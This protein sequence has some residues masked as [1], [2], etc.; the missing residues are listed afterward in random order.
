MKKIP[1][2][3]P[4]LNQYGPVL[5]IQCENAIS[6][7]KTLVSEWLQKYMFASRDAA[8]I[9]QSIA[10]FLTNHAEFKTHARHINGDVA[11]SEGL[12]VEN[13]ESDRKY[14]I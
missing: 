2:W 8:T 9:S 12:V 5:L 13:L 1:V 14:R 11:K 10:A 6:L 4:T 3:Y 7:C